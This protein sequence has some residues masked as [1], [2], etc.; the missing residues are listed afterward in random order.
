MFLVMT[1]YLYVQQY[2]STWP[3]INDLPVLL[4]AFNALAWPI[5]GYCFGLTMWS[6]MERAYETHQ[7]HRGTHFGR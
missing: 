5:A 3:S 6:M 4:I 1:P 2:G 7:Q